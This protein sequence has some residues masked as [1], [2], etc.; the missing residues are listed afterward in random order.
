[1]AAA[2]CNL[3]SDSVRT[4][5][6]DVGGT[7]VGDIGAQRQGHGPSTAADASQPV[8]TW[9]H[10]AHATQCAGSQDGTLL[11]SVQGR[12]WPEA[13][14]GRGRARH[15]V[16]CARPTH[17]QTMG[18]GHHVA[19]ACNKDWRCG[20]PRCLLRRPLLGRLRSRRGGVVLRLL[21]TAS[22][23]AFWGADFRSGPWRWPIVAGEERGSLC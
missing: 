8:P 11:E 7:D 17:H 1:M 4:M 23:H 19:R 20:L 9:L 6:T 5:E 12:R 3:R 21:S 2:H 18:A 10:M 22:L 14:T 15:G 13:T 16:S